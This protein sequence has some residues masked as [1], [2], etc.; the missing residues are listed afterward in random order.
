[1]GVAVLEPGSVF[2][3]YTIERLLGAGGMGEVY[4][5]RHPRLPRRDALKVLAA[6]FAADEQYRRR[7][8]READ[9]VAALSYPGIVTVYDRGETAGRLWIALELI[10][11]PDM[12][13][14]LSRAPHGLPAAEVSRVV[15]AVAETLDFAGARGL[16][17]RDVKPANIL[18]SSG[19]VLLSDF[20][21]AR[22][23][24]GNSELTQTGMALGTLSYASPEQMSGGIVD[25]R[26]DQYSLACSAFHLLTGDPPFT[27]STAAGVIVA[28]ATMPVPSVVAARPDLPPAV[29]QVFFRAMAKRPDDRFP[30]SRAFAAALKWALS[31]RGSDATQV[32]VPGPAGAPHAGSSSPAFASTAHAAGARPEVFGPTQHRHSGG[33][34]S[35][36]RKRS[37]RRWLIVAPVLALVLVV[38]AGVVSWQVFGGSP[39]HDLPHKPV[40]PQFASLATQP[41]KPVWA[42]A[43]KGTL[44]VPQVVGGDEKLVLFLVYQDGYRL[45]AVNA[46]TGAPTGAPP[47]VLPVG[48]ADR[49]ISLHCA[50]NEPATGAVCAWAEGG[51]ADRS[52]LVVI[53]IARGAVTADVSGS[54]VPTV[55]AAGERLVAVI[56][57]GSSNLVAR[58]YDVSGTS[59][60]EVPLV[61]TQGYG[62]GSVVIDGPTPYLKVDTPIATGALGNKLSSKVIRLSD[63]KVMATRDFPLDNPSVLNAFPG[64]FAFSQAGSRAEIFDADGTKTADIDEG[65]TLAVPQSLDFRDNQTM[66]VSAMSL[67]VATKGSEVGAVDPSSGKIIWHHRAAD[68]GTVKGTS[69]AVI[70]G[71]EVFDAYSGD[72]IGER[73]PDSTDLLGT[74]GRRLALLRTYPSSVMTSGAGAGWELSNLDTGEVVAAVGGRLYI[75]GQRAL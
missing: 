23:G 17:H 36:G 74:D 7:F 45:T 63:G 60:A 37:P 50:V 38:V 19:R 61:L 28:H 59:V 20:G 13:V 40:T 33:P 25:T 52:R 67:P 5:A 43:P 55:L 14:V 4:V 51:S 21:I 56:G 64:G 29:D 11:G 32:R 62:P 71:H 73:I 42:F 49:P 34:A 72:Q 75:G 66:V 3:G 41:T 65:W 15:D 54:S 57:R 46:D 1:M 70:V 30:S 24:P 22:M 31:Q 27:G 10:D 58:S 68:S 35:V 69:T 48:S 47:V 39:G 16:V 44:G 53:D 12:N 26:A 9:L 2:A 8:E 18:T 6:Q